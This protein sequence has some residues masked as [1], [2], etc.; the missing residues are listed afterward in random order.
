MI[1]LNR[2]LLDRASKLPRIRRE[3]EY[4]E[5]GTETPLPFDKEVDGFRVIGSGSERTVWLGPDGYVYKVQANANHVA[6]KNEWKNSVKFRST[7]DWPTWIYIPETE[8]DEITKVA[9]AEYI[10]GRQPWQCY[11]EGCICDTEECCWM[12]ALEAFGYCG[13]VDSHA[14]NCVIIDGDSP[15]DFIVA[16]IDFTR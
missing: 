8:Y 15:S 2:E 11:Y 10:Q 6:N 9:V 4:S 3:F 13:S 14:G 1:L 5:D 12:K 16:I 7:P